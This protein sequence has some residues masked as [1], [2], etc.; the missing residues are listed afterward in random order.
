MGR[1]YFYDGWRPDLP[2][3][4]YPR[5]DV[6]AERATIPADW[7]VWAFA[8]L[9]GQRDAFVEALQQARLIDLDGHWRGGAKVALVGL[10]DY[11]DRGPDSRGVVE[12]LTVLEPELVAAGSRLVLVRGN[13]EQMLADIL[14]DSDEWWSSWLLNGGEALVRSHGLRAISWPIRRLIDRL[15][16]AAPGLLA[17]L[18]ETLPMAHWRDTV[19]VHAGLPRGGALGPLLIDDRQLWDPASWF[20]RSAGVAFEPDLWAFREGG[21]RRVVIGHYPQDHGPQVDHDGTLLLLDTNAAGMRSLSGGRMT[22]MVT[23]ARIVPQGP[24]G[25]SEFISVHI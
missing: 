6:A 20:V 23:L 7:T 25:A 8:D 13:H 19:F 24:L 16:E 11:V 18:L 17:W 21:V 14:R 5:I 2:P 15:N 10:G 9:H 12:V 3:L 22:S 4:G 1:F